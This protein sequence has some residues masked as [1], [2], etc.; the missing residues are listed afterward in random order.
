MTERFVDVPGGRLFVIDDGAPGDPPIV[1]LHAGVADSRAWDD[2]APYLVAG[3]YRVVR[4][5]MRGFGRTETEDVEY[6][7]RADVIAVLDALDIGQAVLVGN[8]SGGQVA[9]DTAIEFPDRVAAVVGVAAEPGGFD[10]EPTP[11]ESALFEE[12]DALEEAFEAGGPDAPSAAAIAEF[13]VRLW[14][15][16]PGQPPDRVPAAIRELVREMD[17]LHY[18]PGR[19]QGSPIP[20][21]PR[22]NDRLAEL[23]APV[24]AVAGALDLREFTLA[25][26][27]LAAEL[28]HATAVIWPDVAHMIGMEVPERLAGRILE[29][30][31]PLPRWS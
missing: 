5:D 23:R 7:N 9:Y 11:E 6:S 18:A 14:V 28:P 19:T 8:S 24:L 25:A 22:A 31:A 16:G 3:G 12:A 21:L 1:L 13:E 26:Q 10:A 2:L 4:R 27:H 29:F 30:L 17:V 15:D 20:L